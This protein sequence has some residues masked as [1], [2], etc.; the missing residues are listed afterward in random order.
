MRLRKKWRTSVSLVYV[1]RMSV[2]E[3]DADSGGGGGAA[4]VSIL[5]R[6][7]VSR[8]PIQI[9]RELPYHPTSHMQFVT[10]VAVTQSQ[11]KSTQLSATTGEYTLVMYCIALFMLQYY[12]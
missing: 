6:L 11:L 7:S 2:G 1:S 8:S 3:M 12:R 5:D 9:Q 4:Q 10:I